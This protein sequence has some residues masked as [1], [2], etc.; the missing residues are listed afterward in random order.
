MIYLFMTYN[1]KNLA[2]HC[3]RIF[4]LL[5]RAPSEPREPISPLAMKT[6]IPTLF[7]ALFLAAALLLHLPSFAA[8]PYVTNY[9]KADYR[10]G[11]QNWDIVQ[12]DGGFM[13]FA[14]N[15]GLMEFDGHRW[16]CLPVSNGTN[17]R[18]LCYDAR[19]GRMYA[20]AYAEFGYYAL[21]GRGVMEYTSLSGIFGELGDVSEIWHISR[22][23]RTFYLQD[24]WRIYVFNPDGY[25]GEGPGVGVVEAGA[26]INFSAAVDG[27]LYVACQDRGV[28]ELR[29]DGP[30]G[31]RG[32]MDPG[33]VLSGNDPGT[34]LSGGDSGYSLVPVRWGDAL[35]G[36]KVCAILPYLGGRLL[37][38]TEF[39]GL[40]LYTGR[41]L[42]RLHTEI[43]SRIGRAQVFCAATDGRR[44]A[45]GTVTDGVFI[46]NPDADDGID[47]LNIYSGLQNNSVL[48]L[49]FDAEGNLW[50][51]LD[52]GVD[53]VDLSSPARS[54][55]GTD[56]SY[57]TGY[58]TEVYDGKLYFGTNQGLYYMD[59]GVIQGGCTDAAVTHVKGISGQVWSL[60]VL[61]GDLLCG[62]DGGLFEVR[63]DQAGKVPGLDGIWNVTRYG[64]E[65]G[66]AIGCSYSGLFFLE[67]RGGHWRLRDF[68]RG[69]R[70]ASTNFMPDSD[71]SVWMHHWMK[72]LFRLTLDEALDSVVR[73]EYFDRTAGF[74][75]DRNNMVNRV[76]GAAVFSSEGGFYGYDAASGRMVPDAGLNSL[77]TRPP[78]AAKVMESP[79]GDL[80][81]LSGTMQT[82]A[83]KGEGGWTVDSTSL[84]F[85]RDER[86]PGFD[87]IT[88]ID[89]NDFIINT[90]SGFAVVDLNRMRQRP[91]GAA[92]GVVLR[93]VSR[94]GRADSPLFGSRGAAAES[95]S[96][97]PQ[98][99]RAG[100]SGTRRGAADS[101]SRRL[102]LP[103]RS[104]SVEFEFVAPKYDRRGTM[105]YS[106]RL[107]KYDSDWSDWSEA[108]TKSYTRL[109]AGSY[110][111]RV[112]ARDTYSG[113]ESA[114]SLALT[115]L[116]PWY[117]SAW[118]ICVYVLA[119]LGLMALV[120]RYVDLRMRRRTAAIRREKEEEI[121]RQSERFEAEAREKDAEIVRLRARQL[122]EDL[123][124][125]S[126]DLA[127]STMN[128]IRKNDILIRIKT[129]LDRVCEDLEGGAAAVAGGVSGVGA[130][131]SGLAVKRLQ[132]IRE[133]IVENLGHDDDWQKFS[134]NFDMVYEDYLKRLKRDFP[135]LGVHDLRLCSYL[136]MDLSSKDIASMLN[137][138]V[139][140][141]EMAR[142]RLRR[143]ML[144]SREV[145]L[146]EFLQN[147]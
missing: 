142:Y 41:R 15:N 29:E 2:P 81:F 105:Q 130:K 102:R 111:F 32:G 117:W 144:L 129:N 35:R 59:G 74:P 82:V 112:R 137:M 42:T 141:V 90:E 65:K 113:Q 5:S 106:C 114:T 80:V 67:K 34:V 140:S 22:I 125:K 56:R 40:W 1:I 30:V 86:I 54:L 68:V 145:N 45:V 21:N 84:G 95:A 131:A 7:R 143:K 66:L 98:G 52:R 147:F 104:N 139:R 26:K 127:S 48:S 89:R 8:C 96:A 39:D 79:Y 60:T 78:V 119:F 24:D 121:R 3:R 118:M 55:L 18:S 85:I 57:G 97:L 108:G 122:E 99:P 135:Q 14:N 120:F 4:L 49:R 9:H 116:P 12:S 37:L 87:H 36:K 88:W 44:I 10:A 51:G 16:S 101:L 109:P 17:V 103:H 73:V 13:Y 76:G 58:T 100:A 72:G 134:E 83:V 25:T 20:G 6:T 53:F 136:K 31:G 123:R 47:H 27:T 28:M 126:Q 71:G 115:V 94:P 63:G 91:V 62:S 107:E 124:H 75:T 50:A 11:T 138:S 133:D 128:L 38:A 64:E 77:F 69:F 92:G 61:D 46:V 70:E 146:T 110:V 93:R 132:K 43:D 23:G 19:T 33:T